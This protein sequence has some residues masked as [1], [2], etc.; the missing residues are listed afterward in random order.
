MDKHFTFKID[1][2]KNTLTLN[3]KCSRM[4]NE[5]GSPEYNK[6]REILAENPGMKLVVESGRK[7]KTPH[8]SR[9]LTYKNMERYIRVQDH[10]EELLTTFALVQEESKKEKSPYAYVRT[11]FFKQFPDCY[12]LRMFFAEEDGST[13]M[14]KVP[15]YLD[16]AA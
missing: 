12:A 3:Y 6:V 9:R 4:A 2:A 10:A 8:H 14:T 1:L 5:H 15:R 7:A 11:W 13:I 16:R